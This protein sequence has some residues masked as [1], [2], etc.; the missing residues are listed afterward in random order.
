M[1]LLAAFS[2][3]LLS[4]SSAFAAKPNILFIAVDDLRPWLGCYDPALK[5]S[6]NIDKLAASGRLFT[7]HYVQV[8]TCGAS[9]CALLFGRRAGH[10]PAD[11][12]NEAIEKTAAK[13]PVPSLPALFRRNGYQTVAIG[14]ITHYPGGHSGKDWQDGPEE[15]PGSWDECTMPCGPWKTPEAAMH[16]YAGGAG[17]AAEKEK[18]KPPL[19]QIT[20]ADDKSCP[21]GWTAEAAIARLKELAV[22]GGEKPFFLAV[23]FLKPHLPWVMP[24]PYTAGDLPVPPLPAVASKPDF[25]STWHNSAEFRQY[26]FIEGD[27]FSSTEA[28]LKGRQAYLACVRYTDAQ[29]GKLL[30]A[31]AGSPAAANTVVVLWGDHGFLL[32]EH[33]V[34]GKHCLYE[35]ALHSPLII[36]VPEQAKA[37]AASDAIVETVDIYPTLASCAGLPLPEGLE[38]SSLMPQLR[39]PSAASDGIAIAAWQQFVTVRDDK[40]RLIVS[41]KNPEHVEFYEE[42][43]DP[44]ERTN[45]AASAA[46][47][48]ARLRALII[49][50]VEEKE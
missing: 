38:G 28:A 3:C 34:W 45:A 1:K 19:M 22:T 47:A 42:A 10:F 21:D 6:P 48:V 16:G 49:P 14:K 39:D 9:R 24:Q 7:R 8:P 32:G 44:G 37:G 26:R 12:S 23:G 31:L 29:V 17:R 5:H 2:L 4:A 40:H 30:D 35:E 18:G 41:K 33:G 36:R 46:E 25:P 11:V 13:Q 50:A 20:G 15:L 43:S 27:P